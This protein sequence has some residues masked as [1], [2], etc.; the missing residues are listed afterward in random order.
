MRKNIVTILTVFLVSSLLFG[1]QSKDNLTLETEK[2]SSEIQ[3]EDN[4]QL[5]LEMA[6][7]QIGL[8]WVHF[9]QGQFD[10]TLQ[11]CEASLEFAQGADGLNELAT[12]HNL[13]GGVYYHLGEWRKAF[14][15]T[16]RA[17]V[18]RE[19]MGYSWGVAA[20]LSNLGILA[21]VAGHWQKSISFFERS[22]ALRKEMG[23]V[24]GI[25]ITQNNLGNAYRGQGKPE[26][27]EHY[28]KESINT[29]ET[30]NIAYH[31]ANSSVGLAHV[32]LQQGRV[33]EA[34]ATLAAGIKIGEEI[35]AQDVLAEAHR[36]RAEMLLAQ[37]DSSQ[38][39]EAARQAASLA[40]SVGNRSYEAA[41]WRV[42]SQAAVAQNDLP[43]AETFIVKAANSLADAMDDLE[44]GHVAAQA[45]HIYHLAGK[46]VQAEENLSL[47]REIFNRLGTTQFLAQLEQELPYSHS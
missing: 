23:D 27:A 12:A 7:T 22:L 47:A 3:V 18:L 40:A 39:L 38:A 46:K 10:K 20:T 21:F 35:G 25:A 36:I 26:A 45:Y 14:H 33:D 5:K 8:A 28:F 11:A 42:A 34:Q 43:L 29:A 32:V 16:T 41:A 30:F 13:I 4:N 6:R 31:I 44:T 24:E 2:S 15:H 37:A 9:A 17:M 19:Q 1:C